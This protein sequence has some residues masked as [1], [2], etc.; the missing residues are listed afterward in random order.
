MTPN[1]VDAGAERAEARQQSASRPRW[2]RK[3]L[4]VL[5][6]LLIIAIPAALFTWY[7]FFRQVPQPPSI[8]GDPSTNFLYGSIGSEGEGGIPYWIVVVLHPIQ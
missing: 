3:L 6:V 2:K 1:E 4:K 5:V 8:T 7:K